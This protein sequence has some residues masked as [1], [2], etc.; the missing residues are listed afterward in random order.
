MIE[1]EW[2]EVVPMTKLKE[3]D[4]RLKQWLAD[5]GIEESYLE[6]HDIRQD[7][8]RTVRGSEAVYFLRRSKLRRL[9]GGD[10]PQ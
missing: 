8:H 7:L 6:P 3:A 1:N 9:L 10:A 2:V 4:A 5:H